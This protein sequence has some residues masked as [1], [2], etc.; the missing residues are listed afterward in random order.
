MNDL[1]LVSTISFIAGIF[2]VKLMDFL[3]EKWVNK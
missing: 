1:Y 2:Y 3:W